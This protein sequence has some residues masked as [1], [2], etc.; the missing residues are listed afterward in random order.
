MKEIGDSQVKRSNW[1]VIAIISGLAA[2]VLHASVAS[3]LSALLFYITPLPLLI[4]GL[5]FGWPAAL[6]GGAIGAGALVALWGIK[7]GLF[8]LAASAAGPVI[9]SWL[10]LINRKAEGRGSEGEASAQGVQWYPEGRLVLWAAGMAGVLLTLVI[11]ALGPDA[12]SFQA[13][14]SEAAANISQSLSADIPAEQKAEFGRWI[15]FLMKLAP[16]VSAAA[17]LAGMTLN[18]MISSRILTRLKM[19]PRPWAP[20]S[21]LS[22]PRRA[23]LALA[24]VCALSLMPGTAGLI[25]LVFAAPLLTAFAILGLAVVHHLLIGH[26]ARVPMLT[27]LYAALM[28]FSWVLAL[29]LIA[30]GIAEL[31]LGVRARLKPLP[32]VKPTN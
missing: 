14:L 29:P 25:G 26:S 1:I 24:G 2:A 27:G 32:P 22:F 17:W 3:P 19:S 10:A 23:G 9:L 21:S 12:E 6:L 18:L 15:D 28:L 20:F 8:F 31:G 7:T 13:R 4:A 11:L 16:G 30:L 5:S